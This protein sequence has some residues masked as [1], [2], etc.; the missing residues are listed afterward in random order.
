M[1]NRGKTEIIAQ[2]LE[3]MKEE[4]EKLQQSYEKRYSANFAKSKKAVLEF[5]KELKKE[6]EGN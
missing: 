4:I 1:I 3:S 2:I 5:Q 6:L